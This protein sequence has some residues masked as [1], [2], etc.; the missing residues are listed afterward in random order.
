M[1]FFIMLSNSDPKN[2]GLE[3]LY[4]DDLFEEFDLK[5]IFAKRM[6]NSDGGNRGKI[7]EILVTTKLNGIPFTQA[8]IA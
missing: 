1:G 6:V 5:R 2:S 3:D 4:F 7:S 8:M